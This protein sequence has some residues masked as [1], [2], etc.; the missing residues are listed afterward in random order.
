MTILRSDPIRVLIVD[1]HPV[2]RAGLASM[3]AAHPEIY[4]VGD[5]AN[6]PAALALLQRTTVDVML[7]D[8]RM[9]V[10]NGIAVLK[11]L[12]KLATPVRTIMLTSFETD[13]DIYQAIQAGAL[14]YLSKEIGL[15]QMTEAIRCVHSGRRYIRGDIAE[16]LAARISASGLTARE[17]EILRMV[18][19]GLTNKDIGQTL[20]ISSLTVKNHIVSILNKLD[21]G[22]RT[23]AVTAAI[24]KGLIT[25][26]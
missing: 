4:V 26:E 8:L 3:L 20:N 7:L 25:I 2:V 24:K 9:P 13:E 10:M 11:E 12:K 23:E 21:V 19:R 22:D 6:G 15:Q 17:M 14:G 18:A 5:A 1:D 16:R